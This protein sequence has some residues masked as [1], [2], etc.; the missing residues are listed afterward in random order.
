MTILKPPGCDKVQAT[1]R[2]HKCPSLARLSSHHSPG[3]KYINE[4]P[5]DDFS[6]LDFES[7]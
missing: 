4:E 2:G 6:P 7:L 5:S 3:T 1:Q